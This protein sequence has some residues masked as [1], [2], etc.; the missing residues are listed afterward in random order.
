MKR[1][2]LLTITITFTACARP[3][4]YPISSN[5]AWIEDDNHTLNLQKLAD[6]RHLRR[7]AE[8]AEDVAIRWADRYFGLGPEYEPRRDQCMAAL[9]EGVARQHGVD[10]ALVRQ[11]SSQRDMIV[12]SAVILTFVILYSFAAY[13]F[14]GRILKRFTLDEPGFWVMTV[15]M[16][17]GVSL[18]GLMIS[19]LGS[20]VVEEFRLGSGHLSYRM[21][22]IPFRQHLAVLFLCGTVIF[23][24][25]T[26]AKSFS[27]KKAQ[28]G[29][30]I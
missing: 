23:A 20:I 1:L 30:G 13:V 21:N 28:K 2:L 26:W 14:A 6:R 10:V 8:T 15:T 16:A 17:I 29:S 18:V 24:L 12:D 22:R 3:G 4:D 5:C 7:D 11:Y 25:A 27:H 9:F 19:M